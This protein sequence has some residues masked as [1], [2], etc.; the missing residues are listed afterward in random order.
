MMASGFVPLQT[1]KLLF[2]LTD[3]IRTPFCS[4]STVFT[5]F[6]LTWLCVITYHGLTVETL[7]QDKQCREWTSK[8][9]LICWSKMKNVVNSVFLFIPS[10]FPQCSIYY[11][12]KITG[13]LITHLHGENTFCKYKKET[14]WAHFFVGLGA[15]CISNA[16]M[17]PCVGGKRAQTH[18]TCFKCLF[19]I[20]SLKAIQFYILCPCIFHFIMHD[21][22]GNQCSEVDRSRL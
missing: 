21:N 17:R 18:S 16:L 13:S 20:K 6:H 5:I 4:L 3:G 14:R 9:F 12:Q 15:L 2:S 10:V 1:N 7:P 22:F 19:Q 11:L 8:R